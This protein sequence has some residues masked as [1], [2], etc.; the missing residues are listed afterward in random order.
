[1]RSNR[2]LVWGSVF[3]GGCGGEI[4]RSRPDKDPSP[5][6]IRQVL[7]QVYG[8]TEKD[9]PISG[10][11]DY[12]GA[13]SDGEPMIATDADIT[14]FAAHMTALAIDALL[15]TEPSPYYSPRLS[16]RPSA[17]VAL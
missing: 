2:T 8:T 1:M 15:E 6:D 3:A 14:V 13:T 17:R 11:S 16:H 10:D 4:A 12:D 5:Y 9:P 7:T